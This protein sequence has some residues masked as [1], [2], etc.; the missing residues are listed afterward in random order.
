M[1]EIKFGYYGELY[2]FRSGSNIYAV[3]FII[4]EDENKKHQK[5]KDVLPISA[6][7]FPNPIKLIG[8]VYGAKTAVDNQFKKDFGPN[9]N[10]RRIHV[11]YA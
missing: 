5:Y 11:M 8:L 9:A 2:G 10:I 6:N 4:K 7:N 3:T 1:K